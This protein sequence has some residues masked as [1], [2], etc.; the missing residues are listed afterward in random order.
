[1]KKNIDTKKLMSELGISNSMAV[2]KLVKIV[3]NCGIGAEA[4]KDKKIIEKVAAQL[5]IITGQKPQITRA[6]KAISTFK[7]RAG[8]PVGLRVTL[9]GGR[10]EDFFSRLVNIAIPRVRDF[11]GIP[12]KGFDG[13]GNYTLGIND[14]S[15]FP[16]LEY[17]MIDRTRGFEITIVTT[18]INDEHALH[19]L[20]LL[21]MPF[22]KENQHG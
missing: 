1:M 9:R 19:L 15:I 2:P 21:G 14:Q 8:D 20:T 4:L 11:R 7:L 17:S 12:I 10:M 13:R 5:A 16:D 22:E 3:I 18:A 6:R